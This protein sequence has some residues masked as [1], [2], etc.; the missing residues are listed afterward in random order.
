MRTFAQNLKEM[1]AIRNFINRIIPERYSVISNYGLRGL[2]GEWMVRRDFASLIWYNICD[3]LADILEDVD[4][5]G[6]NVSEE[7]KL[8]F[9]QFK[10]FVYVW[11]RTTLQLLWDKGYCVIGY[12]ST[13]G[14][15]WLMTQNGY[16]ETT[17]GD[18]ST[19]TPYDASVQ[20]YVMRSPSFIAFGMSDK[21][22]C[23]PWLE[24]LDDICN[25]SATVNKRLGAL[26]VASP[27][28][29]TNSSTATVLTKEMKESM[30]KEISEDYGSL[31]NQRNLM[32]LPREM[33]W[34]TINLAGLDLKTLDKA[35]M[36][37]LAICDRLKA[38]A[39]QIAIIDA[40]SMKTLAN[41]SEM[42]E[43]DKAKYKAFRRIFE[44]TFADM[45]RSLGI[46]F[47]Y[48]IKGEPMDEEPKQEETTT[49]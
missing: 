7:G 22:M 8:F 41:G 40:N 31:R 30:E 3:I 12:S 37:I 33:S 28:N 6:G 20:I 34:Q 21:Q 16:Y 9:A 5:K 44:R 35:K 4:M 48:T 19:A 11:G 49:L 18:I 47:E 36:C 43:G 14:A 27:K 2:F 25:S 39:N 29:L 38:P 24:F 45:A 13:R 46:I 1:G 15:F 32:I 23:R 42:R 26:V 10:A 17:K